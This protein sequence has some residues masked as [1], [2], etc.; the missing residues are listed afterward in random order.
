M[1]IADV[2]R[3]LPPFRQKITLLVLVVIAVYWLV[4]T[5]RLHRLR[6]EH[7][8]LWFLGLG[9]AVVVVWCDPLLLGLTALLGVSVPASAL[10]LLALFFMFLM[11]VWLTTVVSWQKQAIAKLI[12]AVSILQAQGGKQQ[13][14]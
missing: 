8:L 6:E 9:A 2:A 4:R 10:L 5:V 1:N 14:H 12:I 7:A 13:T 3:Y 11:L